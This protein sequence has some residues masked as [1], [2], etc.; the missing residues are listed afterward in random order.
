MKN[1]AA[2]KRI[3]SKTFLRTDW[4]GF[5]AKAGRSQ[6]KRKKGYPDEMKSEGGEEGRRRSSPM[7]K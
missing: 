3:G 5:F 2:N 6:E 7:P 4:N 1:I